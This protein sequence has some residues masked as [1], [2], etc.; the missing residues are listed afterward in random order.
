[1]EIAWEQAEAI[2]GAHDDEVE[3]DDDCYRAV[4][5]WN[6][7]SARG[8][9]ELVRWWYERAGEDHEARRRLLAQ[10]AHLLFTSTTAVHE[11]PA[12]TVEPTPLVSRLVAALRSAPAAP[13]RRGAG[14]AAA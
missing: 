3:V 6:G 7:R 4:T 13:P 8:G 11:L 1:M 5:E 12:V 9:P 14:L 2:T 10:L